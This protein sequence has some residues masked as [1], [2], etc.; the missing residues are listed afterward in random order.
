MAEK[1][2][3]R[4][5]AL[6]TVLGLAVFLLGVGLLLL[7][8]KLAYNMFSVPPGQALQ[9]TP[10]QE[11]QVATV[12]PTL[13]GLVLRVF[14]LLVMGVVGSLVANRGVHLYTESRGRMEGVDTVTVEKRSRPATTEPASRES[15]AETR[16]K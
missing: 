2:R 1:V 10:N 13:T 4:R 15:T 11:I 3:G 9:L 7:T 14:L 5:D 12:A 8:F 6:G 16:P